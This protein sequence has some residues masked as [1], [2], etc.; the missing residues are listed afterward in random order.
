MRRRL[1]AVTLAAIPVPAA[2]HDAFGD[3]GPFYAALLHP[4]ADPVQGLML[5]AVALFLARQPIDTVRPA[6][7]TAVAAG[8]GVLVLGQVIALPS[9]GQVALLTAT[10]IAA[11]AVLFK[12]VPDA[13]AACLLAGLLGGLG[14]LSF[15]QVT[16]GRVAVL[17]VLGGAASIAL[18]TLFVWGAA[19]W[20]NRRLSP[21]ATLVAASWVA[22][23]ALMVAVVPA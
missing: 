9:A 6:Y 11:L 17:T 15:D 19:D 13:V 16:G 7:A 1:I 14:A 18:V 21:Y 10:L 3:L 2:A 12:P 20:A 23:V 8:L 22:A 5:A 4:L